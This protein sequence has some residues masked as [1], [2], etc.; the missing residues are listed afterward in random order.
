LRLDPHAAQVAI[1]AYKWQAGK[2]RPRVYGDKTQI[3]H[4]FDGDINKL[5]IEEIENLER[6]VLAA[7]PG[8]V[9]PEGVKLIEEA[10]EEVK[11]EPDGK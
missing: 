9:I 1:D 2:L 4:K 11:E 3:T 8:L 5:S 6:S 7:N 10:A